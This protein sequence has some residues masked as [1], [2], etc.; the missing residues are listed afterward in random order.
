M[1][2]GLLT[3]MDE[4]ERSRA[5]A[6]PPLTGELSESLRQC[7][8]EDVREGIERGGGVENLRVRRGDL[9]FWSSLPHGPWLVAKK[10]SRDL[11]D[12]KRCRGV[13]RKKGREKSSKL[14]KYIAT[15]FSLKQEAWQIYFKNSI[16][17][18]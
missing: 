1:D 17:N 15:L 8:G 6:F 11:G 9:L 14:I 10:S 7:M 18:D 2:V 4:A 12:Q 13:E 3:T 5:M 16:Q